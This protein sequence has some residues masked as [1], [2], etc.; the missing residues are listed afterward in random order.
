MT[1]VRP[2][3][4][5]LCLAAILVVMP[6][7]TSS[8]ARRTEAPSAAATVE[9]GRGPQ[10]RVITLDPKKAKGVYKVT[11]APGL[12][13]VLKLPEPWT[14]PPTCGDC[15]FGDAKQEGQ[16]WRIDVF[17][18]TQSFSI[19][20]TRLPGPDLP[21]TAFVTN[22]DVTL[23]GGL[24]VAIF[25][26]LSLPE[27]ADARV[28]FALPEAETGRARLTVLERQLEQRFS[29][30]ARALATELMLNAAMRGTTCRDFFGR[31]NRKDNVV[32]RL[33]QICRTSELL[34]VTFEVEN[35]RRADVH[36]AAPTLESAKGA[37]AAGHKLEKAALRFNER[38]LGIAAVTPGAPED[39]DRYR[40]TVTVAGVD[41]ET[42]VV[43]EDIDL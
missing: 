22:L 15:V 39:P 16:L 7:G 20:P 42:A 2:T 14:T 6:A 35:R 36:L 41:D 12:A 5:G 31:P 10:L 1:G 38:A 24:S 4:L 21:A 11:A 29:D 23:E 27:H 40:L 34:Y 18:E 25:V 32:V 9:S 13:T 33:K 8:A 43:V 19:K 37:L 26:E 30:R 17:P 28:E 3:A